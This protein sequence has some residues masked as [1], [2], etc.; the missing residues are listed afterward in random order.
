MNRYV[1]DLKV[2][3]GIISVKGSNSSKNEINPPTFPTVPL[4]IFAKI[5]PDNGAQITSEN[6]PKNGIVNESI[7]T[8]SKNTL[9][10]SCCIAPAESP[11]VD[12]LSVIL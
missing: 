2:N 10:I 11:L 3:V 7:P 5:N 12:I 4:Y 9:K 6:S 8:A 1:V